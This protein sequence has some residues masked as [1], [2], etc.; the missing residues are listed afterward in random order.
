MEGRLAEGTL[1]FQVPE[2][3]QLP[4]ALQEEL[5]GQFVGGGDV[6][7]DFR[8]ARHQPGVLA[9]SFVEDL[10]VH[11]VP[12]IDG[13]GVVGRRLARVAVMGRPGEDSAEEHD[14]QPQ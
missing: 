2:P 10:P 8:N 14:S 6:E 5:A 7:A 13:L 1:G 12:R 11:G 9:W 4:H 3:V